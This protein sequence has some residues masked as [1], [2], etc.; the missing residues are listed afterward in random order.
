MKAGGYCS[1]VWCAGPGATSTAREGSHQGSQYAQAEGE[2][3]GS[4]TQVEAVGFP[5]GP[6]EETLD[7]A[8]HNR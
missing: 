7:P 1:E 2:E 5:K 6:V 8:A 4:P 3:V